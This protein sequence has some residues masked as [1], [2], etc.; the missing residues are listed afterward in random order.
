MAENVAKVMDVLLNASGVAACFR[1]PM[2]SMADA[3]KVLTLNTY[4]ITTLRCGSCP[5]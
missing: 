2:A 1:G 5:C 3:L 4:S